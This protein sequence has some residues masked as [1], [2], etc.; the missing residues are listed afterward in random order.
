MVSIDFFMVTSLLNGSSP[1]GA[2][3]IAI[4]LNEVSESQ[5]ALK[6]AGNATLP[7]PLTP[8]TVFPNKL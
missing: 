8:V 1:A 6:L 5:V 2:S 4:N 3:A 7:S